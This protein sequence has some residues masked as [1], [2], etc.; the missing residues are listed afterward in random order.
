MKYEYRG[1]VESYW[2][3]KTKQLGEKLDLSTTLSTTNITLA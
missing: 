1:F 3:M 2:Q